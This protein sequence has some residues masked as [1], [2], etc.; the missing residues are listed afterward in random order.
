V[1]VASLF[2]DYAD[3]AAYCASHK[4]A[5]A[6]GEWTRHGLPDQPIVCACCDATLPASPLPKR[7]RPL[8]VVSAPAIVRATVRP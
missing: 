4:P 5:C 1:K 2:L 8:T 3:G 6:D 7:M